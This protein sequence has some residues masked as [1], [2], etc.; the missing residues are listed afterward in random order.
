MYSMCDEVEIDKYAQSLKSIP[1]PYCL[2]F[3][4]PVCLTVPSFPS[5]AELADNQRPP[6][7]VC[8]VVA[9]GLTQELTL[10][11]STKKKLTKTNSKKKV[12]TRVHLLQKIVEGDSL[13]RI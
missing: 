2:R 1:L 3:H 4:M 12:Q 10:I 7:C 11:L 6:T 8:C 5:N 9:V 13:G